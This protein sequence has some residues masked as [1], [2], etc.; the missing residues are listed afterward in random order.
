MALPR[1]ISL[2]TVAIN[3]TQHTH[4]ASRKFYRPAAITPIPTTTAT[5]SESFICCTAVVS[6]AQQMVLK[7]ELLLALC[8]LVAASPIHHGV[9]RNGGD[10]ILNDLLD[11]NAG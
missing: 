1:Q 3:F 6:N 8:A 2:I 9:K 11:L 7:V 4:K 10:G 5:V